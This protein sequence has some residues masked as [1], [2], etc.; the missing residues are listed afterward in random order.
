MADLAQLEIRVSDFV[1]RQL[2]EFLAEPERQA[3]SWKRELIAGAWKTFAL[4]GAALVQSQAGQW[5]PVQ[6]AGTMT[7]LPEDLVSRAADL[8]RPV[9]VSPWVALPLRG[10]Q[11]SAQVILLRWPEGMHPPLEQV[12]ERLATAVELVWEAGSRLG[13][14]QRQLLRREKILDAAQ[15]WISLRDTERLFEDIARTATEILECERATI[16]LWN[17]RARRLIGRPAL[18]VPGGQLILPDD[19]GVVGRVIRTGKAA[20]ADSSSSPSAIDHSVDEQLG[21]LT[22]SV[23]CVPLRGK[24]GLQ[25]AF[26]VLNKHSGLF[27]DE[28]EETLTEI[29]AFAAAA[30][31]NAQEHQMLLACHNQMVSQVAAEVE[32]VGVSKAI[33]NIRTLIRRVADTDL[34]VL[35]LG[36]NGTGKEVVARLIHFQSRRKQYPFLAVNCA[37]IPETLAESE[38]F[39]HERGAFTDAFETRP[40]KF[41]LAGKGTLFLDEVGELSLPCQAK[42]LRVLEEKSFVRVGGTN[43]LTCE[44]RIIAA[45]NQDLGQLVR[46]RRFREDLFY[47]LNGLTI[48]LPPLR[49]RKEDIPLLARHFLQK[50]CLLARRSVPRL[51]SAAEQFLCSYPWPG[52]V[53]E[54]R[55]AMERVAYLATGE[56]IDVDDLAFLTASGPRQSLAAIPTTK[57]GFKQF[58]STTLTAATREFQRQLV[59]A[60]L[61]ET[62]GNLTEAA[63]RL[64]LHRSNLY[65]KLRQLGISPPHVKRSTGWEESA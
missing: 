17:R 49:A 40:G 25:G 42:L 46:A 23:L 37:A 7:L 62:G 18:G 34:A 50:F 55:N 33:E 35:I 12:A 19:R 53:R 59:E 16:F 43:P 8:G 1:F 56:T 39:G 28:D 10:A 6:V 41:E 21:F 51:T 31:E 4:E 20:R 47:R 14:F 64:G 3:E 22:R 15:R 5:R 44:A 52:N 13:R 48:E 54:L 9:V 61:A 58:L 38:L 27:S 24:E 11:E 29:A 32:L 63:R 26:E 65:R 60:V 2:A 57:D 36:E 30:L 45:T